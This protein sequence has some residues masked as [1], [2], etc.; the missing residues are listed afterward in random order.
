MKHFIKENHYCQCKPTDGKYL[1]TMFTL[2]T[3]SFTY[4]PFLNVEYEDWYLFK[5]ALYLYSSLGTREGN[6]HCCSGAV[7]L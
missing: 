1:I 3:P 7:S 4:I 6:L 2:T 5:T